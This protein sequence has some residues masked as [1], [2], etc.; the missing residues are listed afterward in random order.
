MSETI[1]G[2]PTKA[3]HVNIVGPLQR[4]AVVVHALEARRGGISAL[5]R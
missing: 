4:V 1:L 3:G 5:L 2:S